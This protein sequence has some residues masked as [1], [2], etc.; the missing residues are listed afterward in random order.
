[1]HDR[2]FDIRYGWGEVIG[3]E[4]NG[5]KHVKFETTDS[6]MVYSKEFINTIL[7]YT[8][9][10]LDGQSLPSGNDTWDDLR[11]DWLNNG[12]NIELFTWLRMNYE[13]PV[14]K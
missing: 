4:L 7:S 12:D 11:E 2:V 6:I 13:Q 10:K 5:A 9:Y 1:M 14:R 3:E 8:E